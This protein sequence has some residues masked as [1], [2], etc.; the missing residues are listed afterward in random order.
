MKKGACI[1]VPIRQQSGETTER[2]LVILV[3]R[4]VLGIA[5][6][7]DSVGLDWFVCFHRSGGLGTGLSVLPI[8]DAIH[9]LVREKLPQLSGHCKSGH[10]QVPYLTLHMELASKHFY[11]IALLE[12][13]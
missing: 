8:V 7:M 9:L 13:R 6:A 5:V 4:G 10:G 2:E 11:L 3:K 1:A 12:S